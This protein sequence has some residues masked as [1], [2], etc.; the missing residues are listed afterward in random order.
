[1][2][3]SVLGA[4]KQKRP[5]GG[6]FEGWRARQDGTAATPPLRRFAPP[7]VARLRRAR[8]EPVTPAIGVRYFVF[9]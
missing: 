2:V 3:R 6:A 4:L 5:R 8:I 1:M 9:K 7:T